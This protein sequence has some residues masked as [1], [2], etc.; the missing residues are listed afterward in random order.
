[1][2][3]TQ[4]ICNCRITALAVIWF[5]SYF[6]NCSIFLLTALGGLPENL[7]MTKAS[8]GILFGHCLSKHKM[9]RYV[10]NL[11]G[12]VALPPGYAYG[13]KKRMKKKEQYFLDV[14]SSRQKARKNLRQPGTA[15][16]PTKSNIVSIGCCVWLLS[17]RLPANRD[18]LL[19]LYT[20]TL[21][22]SAR[23]VSREFYLEKRV[24]V[25]LTSYG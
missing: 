17:T 6:P 1:M 12:M 20:P 14:Q 23:T 19:K 5:M 13:Y 25:G 3:Q 9:T 16:T 2:N 10:R 7:G 22:K 4:A 8:N 18:C 15:E 24:Y 21:G 11:G